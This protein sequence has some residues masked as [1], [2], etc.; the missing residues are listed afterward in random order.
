MN[1]NADD[2]KIYYH[3]DVDPLVLDRY[4][5]NDVEK[6]NPR[7]SQNG[8]IV[9]AKKHQTLVTGHTDHQFSFPMK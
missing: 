7:Y 9:N 5:S 8:M 2:H 4:I 1:D 6:A 3:S